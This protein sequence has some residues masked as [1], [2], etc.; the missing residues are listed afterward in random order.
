MCRFVEAQTLNVATPNW[1]GQ[2]HPNQTL[3]GWCSPAK[4]CNYGGGGGQPVFRAKLL[5]LPGTVLRASSDFFV[6]C[7]E[8]NFVLG[9]ARDLQ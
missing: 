9:I 6:K 4:Q 5:R 1:A 2:I 3:P 8:L 7:V